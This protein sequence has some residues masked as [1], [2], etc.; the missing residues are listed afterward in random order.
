MLCGIEGMAMYRHTNTGP[1][2]L[3][4]TE[5]PAVPKRELGMGRRDHAL[6]QDAEPAR[7]A[8]PGGTPVREQHRGLL[9]QRPGR[10]GGGRGKVPSDRLN[11]QGHRL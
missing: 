5:R 7:G 6:D 1:K 2:S 3:K 11:V 8:A 9:D 10:L 4:V